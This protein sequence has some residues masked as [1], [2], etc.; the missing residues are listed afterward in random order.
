[1]S[2]AVTSSVRKALTGVGVGFGGVG[3]GEHG[4]LAEHD[5]ETLRACAVGANAT[6]T[7][8][9]TAAPRT[10]VAGFSHGWPPVTCIKSAEL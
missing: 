6:R 5:E 8:A 10:T 9:A 7:A 4:E 2:P 3:L 1:M